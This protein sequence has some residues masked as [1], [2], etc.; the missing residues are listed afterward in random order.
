M[1]ASAETLPHVKKDERMLW[2]PAALLGIFVIW[3]PVIHGHGWWIALIVLWLFTLVS[4]PWFV[5]AMFSL[6][7]IRVVQQSRGL[8][9]QL[10]S[11]VGTIPATVDPL[12][13]KFT[14]GPMSRPNEMAFELAFVQAQSQPTALPSALPESIYTRHR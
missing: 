14:T 2:I 5:T 3:P 13:A 11:L 8:Q 7:L 4:A 10:T 1:D 12:E 6:V 9:H